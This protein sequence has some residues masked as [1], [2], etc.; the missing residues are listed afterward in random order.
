MHGP[1]SCGTDTQ[2]GPAAGVEQLAATCI[3]MGTLPKLGCELMTKNPTNLNG[4][5]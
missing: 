5:V 2:K 4:T 1:L 3:I